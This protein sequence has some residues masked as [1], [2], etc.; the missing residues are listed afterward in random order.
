[1]LLFV[2]GFAKLTMMS[3]AFRD[4]FCVLATAASENHS[5]GRPKIVWA[6]PC[7]SYRPDVYL[8]SAAAFAAGFFAKWAFIFATSSGPKTRRPEIR[9]RGSGTKPWHK[10][11]SIR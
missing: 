8:G 4:L 11:Y 5:P 3:L 10:R 6:G 9:R 1:M 7:C 2:V